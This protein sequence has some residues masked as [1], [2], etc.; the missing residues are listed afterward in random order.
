MLATIP[1]LRDLTLNSWQFNLSET[2]AQFEKFC[3]ALRQCKN[4]KDVKLH[5][6]NEQR[7]HKNHLATC[8][9]S[10]L[11]A[12]VSHLPSLES[13]SVCFYTVN[14]RNMDEEM[15]AWLAGCLYQHWNKF[16]FTLQVT[17]SNQPFS[18]PDF[19]LLFQSSLASVN[20]SYLSF[21]I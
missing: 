4:I 19:G 3:D 6:V 18:L 5:N 7:P 11:H 8:T 9:T 20:L 13:V 16:S 14:A 2:E 21:S 17:I 15:A 12:F 1:L 10:L